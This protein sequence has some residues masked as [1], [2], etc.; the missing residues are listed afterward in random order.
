MRVPASSSL[1]AEMGRSSQLASW[2]RKEN[3]AK[4]NGTRNNAQNYVEEKRT[5]TYYADVPT[6]A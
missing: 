5:F 2:G 3:E 4:M 1:T 6:I